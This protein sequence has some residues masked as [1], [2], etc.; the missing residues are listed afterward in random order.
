[1]PVRNFSRL[2]L[3]FVVLF[4][5]LV[6]AN[7]VPVQP[8]DPAWQSRIGTVLVNAG[9]LP[10]TALAFLLL[11]RLLDAK[12]PLIQRRHQRFARLAIAAAIGYLLLAPLMISA[13]LRLQS[14]AGS[15]QRS[16]LARAERQLDSLRRAVTQSSSSADLSSRFQSLSGPTISPAELALPLPVLKAQ[17]SLALDQAQAQLQ[18]QRN[19][20]PA[21]NPLRLLPELLRN[22]LSCLA[23]A[24]G[25]AIFARAKNSDLSLLDSWQ[26]SLK[27][28]RQ[29]CARR[30]DRQADEADYIRQLSREGDEPPRN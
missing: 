17:S 4:A 11:A 18:R 22:A 28:R 26:I 15:E 9:T 16:R 10:L 20:L 14:S 29:W 5:V 13:S 24:F 19:A 1:M 3:V 23:L 30:F 7:L 2:A 21:S 6:L 27:R 8:F 25:F 12:D